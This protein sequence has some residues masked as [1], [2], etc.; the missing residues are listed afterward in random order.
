VLTARNGKMSQAIRGSAIGAQRGWALMRRFPDAV[1]WLTI[2]VSLTVL[3]GW[4]AGLTGLTTLTWGFGAM[5][6]N[7]AVCQ[8][9]LALALLSAQRRRDAATPANWLER[10]KFDADT[11]TT[12]LACTAGGIAALT[13][14]QY[15]VPLD[16]RIDQLL[17][18]VPHDGVNPY[19]GR[20]AQLTAFIFMLSASAFVLR[21][22]SWGSR[23]RPAEWCALLAG[24][25][26]FM[27]L[28]GYAFGVDSVYAVQAF[29]SIDWLPALLLVLQ[30]AAFLLAFPRFVIAQHV[31]AANVGGM[32]I[33]RLWPAVM[34]LPPLFAFITL[35]GQRT[36][37]YATEFGFA[38]FTILMVVTFSVLVWLTA[39]MLRSVRLDKHEA[40]KRLRDQV[41][42]LDLLNRISRAMNEGHDV[43]AMLQ[44]VTRNLE[45]QLPA[46]LCCVCEYSAADECA[47]TSVGVNTPALASMVTDA[48][49]S[50][51]RFAG[52]ALKSLLAKNLLYEPDALAPGSEALEPIARAGLRSVII[53]PL[54]VEDR[55]LGLLIVARR[56][57]ASFLSGECEFVRQLSQNLSLA[58]AQSQMFGEL[59]SALEEVQQGQT[60]LL[61]QGRLRA[62]G[63]M[64]SGVAH[65]INN[66]ISPIS[67][68]VGDILEREEGLTAVTRRELK[69][70]LRA[71]QD[72]AR[73]VARM[74]DFSG[75]HDADQAAESLDL[76]RII[77]EVVELTRPRW[78]DQ[79]QEGGHAIDLQTELAAD[80][81][82]IRGVSHE[83]GDALTNLIFN[84]ID[85]MPGGGLLR[86]RSFLTESAASVS[87]A[88]RVPML[89]FEVIDSGRG[90]TEDVRLRCLEPFFTTK[91]ERGTGLGLAMV[92]GMAMRHGGTIVVESA[93]GQ[94]TTVRVCLPIEHGLVA[95]EVK[96]ATTAPPL[97]PRKIL[98]VDD[99]PLILEALQTFLE[100]DGHAVVTAE[101]GQ[102]GIDMFRKHW[103][104][105]SQFSIVFT[106]L[107]MPDVDGHRVAAVVKSLS[108]NI[109]VVMLTGWGEKLGEDARPLNVDFMLSKPP[110]LEDLRKVLVAAA[111]APQPETARIEMRQSPPIVSRS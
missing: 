20:M 65:D 10:L 79:T 24:F 111:P 85:A 7:T 81:P 35:K 41:A 19:P 5:R 62:L 31:A 2:V 29:S 8:L 4:I 21:S 98:L 76:N 83:I 47:L 17:A 80:A 38:L 56:A 74:R 72:V 1:A 44:V 39:R 49:V 104:R 67:I 64:A 52:Q 48:G 42:R 84:A 99:D 37:L 101:G 70:I 105:G 59:N 94:G 102:I 87:G 15:L 88:E 90:M 69:T 3:V 54:R 68:Y 33:R 91:G 75:T 13:M 95:S 100:R 30:S 97:L 12:G 96:I 108:G 23:I 73:T 46:D 110:L 78:G 36:Q 34:L 71:T 11:L 51:I 109:P 27:G 55:T 45:V 93:P 26:G 107:G 92:Y 50:S 22:V 40:R 53:A 89:C 6:P 60:A 9:L 14:L 61:Q 43:V 16:L 66:A 25:L 106:D 32:L 58:L 82:L 18:K 28:V 57:P 77:D 86:V 63:E 103:A